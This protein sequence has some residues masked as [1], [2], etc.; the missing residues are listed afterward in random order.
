MADTTLNPFLEALAENNPQ[1]LDAGFEGLS[2]E[3]LATVNAAN[4]GISGELAGLGTYG[5]GTAQQQT[6]DIAS[7][8]Q[9]IGAGAADPRFEAY[10]QAQLNLLENQ[11]QAELGRSSGMLSRRGLGGS[12]AEQ[13]AASSIGSRFDQQE[14]SLS[15]QLGMQSLGRQDSA[16]L[17]SLGA[18]GQTA[19]IAQARAGLAGQRAALNQQNLSNTLAQ[20]QAANQ[21]RGL[22]LTAMTTGLQNL[23]LPYALETART[24]ANNLA[25]DDDGDGG[26]FGFTGILDR[27]FGEGTGD[28]YSLLDIGTGGADALGRAF[29]G[30]GK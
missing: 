23:T 13:N 20:I 4:A 21:A 5:M 1:L 8:L 28:K 24:A 26:K 9:N 6:A 19:N 22:N 3:Q 14:Q 25:G 12:A 11:R 10:R 18:L 16:L 27:T 2:D 7:A 15:S 30:G 29:T 17:N